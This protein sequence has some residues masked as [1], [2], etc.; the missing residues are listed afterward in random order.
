MWRS[1]ADEEHPTGSGA[2]LVPDGGVTVG[3]LGTAIHRSLKAAA[4]KEG[5]GGSLR[6]ILRFAA[7]LVVPSNHQSQQNS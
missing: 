3:Y 5:A 4:Q 1:G 6:N 7:S 2:G